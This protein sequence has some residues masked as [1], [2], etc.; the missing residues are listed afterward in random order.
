MDC[1]LSTSRSKS[2]LA[3]VGLSS[4]RCYN[5]TLVCH[6][7]DWQELRLT[8][9]PVEK[10]RKPGVFQLGGHPFRFHSIEIE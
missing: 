7:R 2:Y 4:E 10:Q 6:Q 1:P 9:C 5:G 3:A 8:V